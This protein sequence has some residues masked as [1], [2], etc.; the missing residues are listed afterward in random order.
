MT[1]PRDEPAGEAP[2]AR[3]GATG[4]AHAAPAPSPVLPS[5]LPQRRRGPS[6]IAEA[7]AGMS[8]PDA[9]TGGPATPPEASGPDAAPPMSDAAAEFAALTAAEPAPSP[10]VSRRGAGVGASGGVASR[11]RSAP[12]AA[13]SAPT[14][15]RKPLLAGA[16][17]VGAVLI[18]VPF[19]LIDGD[20]D[21]PADRADASTGAPLPGDHWTGGETGAYGSAAPPSGSPSAQ[22]SR[23]PATDQASDRPKADDT[24]PTPDGKSTGTATQAAPAASATGHPTTAGIRLRSHASGRCLDVTDGSTAERTPLQIWD[25]SGAARQRWRLASDGT[26]RALGMCMDVDG[27]SRDDGATIQLTTCNG[28]GAQQFHLNAAHDLVNVQADKC[29]DVKDQLTTNGTRIQLW[30]CTGSQNQK[31]ST[32]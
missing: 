9:T 18:A 31:W 24:T 32:A 27:G 13:A 17:F 23:G 25:C 4:E 10:A 22:A 1:T 16:A 15:P 30:T 14:R 12:L 7:S 29:V 28:T 26:V 6:A 3:P 2:E 21:R 8:R 19:L 20:G 11:T 5:P